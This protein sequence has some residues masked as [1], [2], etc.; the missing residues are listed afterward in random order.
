M[1]VRNHNRQGQDARFFEINRTYHKTPK[2]PEEIQTLA[3]LDD[4][5]ADY[6]RGAFEEIVRFLQKSG[7]IGV[8]PLRD[9]EAPDGYERGTAAE[10]RLA[11][12]TFAIYGLITKKEAERHDVSSTP[13]V[14]EL[15]L[16]I[17]AGSSNKV[18]WYRP[19]PRY[20]SIRRDL[21]IV[22]SES[23]LWADVQKV[24]EESMGNI[25]KDLNLPEIIMEEIHLESVYR[26]KGLAEGEKSLAFAMHFRSD[27]DTLTDKEANALTD[28]VLQAI[29]SKFS[30]SRLR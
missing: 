17:L 27:S 13:G 14:G 5:G 29:V 4:R 3:I 21:A 8:R 30:G 19:L 9:S 22:I 2:G 6:V 23:V 25:P 28:V 12:V 24:V 15:A 16:A 1:E 11:D 10:L 20:P 26:G 7:E 18:R